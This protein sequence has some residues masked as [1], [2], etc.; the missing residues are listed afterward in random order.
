MKKLKIVDLMDEDYE[1]PLTLE[2]I[3]EGVNEALKYIEE[4][5]WDREALE[6][7]T[8]DFLYLDEDLPRSRNDDDDEPYLMVRCALGGDRKGYSFKDFREA[9]ESAMD[10]EGKELPLT[11]PESHYADY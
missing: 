8:R 2:D 5:E 1:G 7:L 3:R 11:I 6:Y 9:I 4:L 10:H